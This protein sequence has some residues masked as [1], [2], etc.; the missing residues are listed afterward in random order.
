[1]LDLLS[2]EWELH[3][4]ALVSVSDVCSNP[5]CI[6]PVLPSGVQGVTSMRRSSSGSGSERSGQKA[7]RSFLL[8]RRLLA[9]MAKYAPQ[10]PQERNAASLRA[11]VSRWGKPSEESSPLQVAEESTCPFSEDMSI[12]FGQT[13]RVVCSIATP[14]GKH[15]RYLLLHDYWLLLVQPDLTTPGWAVVKTQWPIRSVQSWIDRSD[16]RTLRVGMHALRGTASHGEAN[17]YRQSEPGL[18]PIGERP[19]SYLT[20]SL[21]FEDVKKCHMVDKH[22]QKRRQEVRAIVLQ[23]AIVFLDKYCVEQLP[24]LPLGSV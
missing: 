2:E 10:V 11:V 1:M 24:D 22:L 7:I 4:A 18:T 23:Q 3:I 15:T 20:L 14:Q 21:S 6:L 16:P 17:V 9:D 12:E 8:L 13:D 19:S 5:R